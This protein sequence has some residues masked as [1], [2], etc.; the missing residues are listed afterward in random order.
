MKRKRIPPY[1]G[2]SSYIF[3]SYAHRDMD[4]V[5]K[6]LSRLSAEGVRIWYD[7]G[8]DPGTEWDE[9]IA[10]HVENCSGMIAFISENYLESENCKD[11][12]NYARELS[13]DRILVYLEAAKLPSGMAMRLNRLQAI[14][15]YTYEDENMFFEK[16]LDA[17][18]VENCRDEFSGSEEKQDNMSDAEKLYALADAYYE[19]DGVRKDLPK[20]LQLFAQAAELGHADSQFMAGHCY[21]VG[22]GTE[23]DYPTAYRFYLSAAKQ[24]DCR[25]LPLLRDRR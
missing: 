20:A 24:N 22:E 19:G 23:P 2:S 7:E 11:E 16:L 14:H 8:I 15:K 18:M 12:L 25:H 6:I 1:E 10:K 3:F 5:M 21:Y 13:K 4:R 17:P 9:Y